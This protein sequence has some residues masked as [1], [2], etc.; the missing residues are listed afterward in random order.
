MTQTKIKEDVRKLLADEIWVRE[1]L[2][3]D[4]NTLGNDMGM[5][6]FDVVTLVVQI[7]GKFNIEFPVSTV[8]EV[9]KL[10]LQEVVRFIEKEVNNL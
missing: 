5:D 7:E 8:E 4:D 3:K 6:S 2:I 10:T 1:E 9:K